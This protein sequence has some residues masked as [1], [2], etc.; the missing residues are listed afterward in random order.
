MFKLAEIFS[1]HGKLGRKAC[2]ITNAG[3]LGVLATD[4]LVKAGILLPEIPEAVLIEL[5]KFVPKGYSRRNSLDILGDA[6]ADRYDKTLR[7]LNMYKLFD[8]FVVILSPQ[9]MTQPLETVNALAKYKNV[10]ACYIGGKSFLEA[11]KLLKEKGIISFD[12]VS[13]LGIL[14]KAT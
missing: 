3:G 2:I 8:F 4:S 6:L 12:D 13:E 1:K 11:R 7:I 5:D 10:F 14:G 9:E